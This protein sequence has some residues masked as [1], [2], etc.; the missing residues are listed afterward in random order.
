MLENDAT[1]AKTDEC[2]AYWDCLR[3]CTFTSGG[4]WI[5]AAGILG[6]DSSLHQISRRFLDG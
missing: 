5:V 1:Q 4:A 3:N 2:P 6:P